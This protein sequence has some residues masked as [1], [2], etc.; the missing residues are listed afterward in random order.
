M[1]VKSVNKGITKSQPAI[2]GAGLAKV[3]DAAAQA[4]MLN[5]WETTGQLEA[6]S[7]SSVSQTG[8]V[9]PA[10][11]S[12]AAAASLFLDTLKGQSS[13]TARTYRTGCRRLMWFVY[14]SGR[15]CPDRLEIAS[16]SPTIL[17]DFYLWLVAAYGRQART[18]HSN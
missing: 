18:T 8:P 17:E 14:S 3:I 1:R 4:V 12:L 9:L 11:L 15:G 7:L 10:T 6:A 5:Q 2:P 13:A 16:L